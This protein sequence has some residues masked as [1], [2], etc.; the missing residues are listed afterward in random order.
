M[1]TIEQT[2]VQT[3]PKEGIVRRYRARVAALLAFVTCLVSPGIASAS[4]PTDATGG[5]GANFIS[6]LQSQFLNYVVPAS[7]GLMVAVLGISVLVAWGRKAV[8]SR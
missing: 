5:A 1:R 6:N 3:E 2:T 4:T 8:K 7:L